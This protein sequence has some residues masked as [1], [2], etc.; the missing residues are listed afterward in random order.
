L[1]N[2]YDLGLTWVRQ[3]DAPYFF[4]TSQLFGQSSVSINGLTQIAAIDCELHNHGVVAVT[5]V[6]MG[7]VQYNDTIGGFTGITHDVYDTPGAFANYCTAVA[8]LEGGVFGNHQYSI[9]GNEGNTGLTYGAGDQGYVS[10]A[11]DRPIPIPTSV[12]GT[13]GVGTNYQY[14]VTAIVNGVETL[15]SSEYYNVVPATTGHQSMR[16]TWGPYANATSYNI[17]GRTAGSELKLASVATTQTITVNA[18]TYIYYTDTNG[19]LPSG[20]LPTTSTNSVAAFEGEYVSMMKPCYQAIKAADP[21]AYVWG[22]RT[23]YHSKFKPKFYSIC[24]R[25]E[26]QFRLWTWY[27]L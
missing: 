23:E 4:D 1:D 18:Q 2:I 11:P 5:G 7:P 26:E 8:Q 9:P 19:T 25:L 13:L 16:I 12:A 17:Y 10:G 22:T 20:A 3:T 21:L 14:R 27:M 15:P 24:F 6:E